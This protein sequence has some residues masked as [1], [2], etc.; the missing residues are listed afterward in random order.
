[1][2]R[3]GGRIDAERPR[4]TTA[5]FTLVEMVVVLAIIALL[6]AVVSVSLS[7]M[8]R[9]RSM[10]RATGTAVSAFLEAREEALARGRSLRVEWR[11]NGRIL[12]IRSGDDGE[13][14][15][16]EKP[17]GEPDRT[18]EPET[19][20]ELPQ[21][22][23]FGGTGE[24]AIVFH[25]DGTS[26]GGTVEIRCGEDGAAKI[27]VDALFGMPRVGDGGPPAVVMRKRRP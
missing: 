6:T 8:F 10:R 25:P 19:V 26:T 4:R 15:A 9:S 14:G 22:C 16:G 27:T 12:R 18:R 13:T 23:R 7:G 1:M 3:P 17:S 11:A 20:F 5:S 24:S 21:E 2:T